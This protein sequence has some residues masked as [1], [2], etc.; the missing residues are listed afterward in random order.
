MLDLTPDLLTSATLG[1]LVVGPL[2]FEEP[3][4]L[5]LIPIGWALTIWIGWKTIAGLSTWSRR[6]AI[7]IRLIVILILACALA[8]PN[9][10]DVSQD[11]AV[12]VV[13]DASDSVPLPERARA[14]LWVEE[15][16]K[17]H[18]QEKDD[19]FGVI[20]V[21]EDASV[22]SLPRKLTAGVDRAIPHEGKGTNLAE[23][24]QL[25]LAVR[26]SDAAYRLVLA[27]DGNETT[28]D[29]LSAARAAAVLSVPIDV[30]I[31]RYSHESEVIVEDLIAPATARMG[32]N[33]NLR[34][35]ITGTRDVSGSIYVTMNGEQ[36]DLDPEGEGMGYRVIVEEG[37]QV[38]TVPIALPRDGPQ[39]FVARFEPDSSGADAIPNNNRAMATTFVGGEGR[40]LLYSQSREDSEQLENVLNQA[41]IAT[42]VTTPELGP[43]DLIEF[44]A[45]DAIILNNVSAYSFSQAQMEDLRRYVYD[46]GGGLVMVGGPDSLGAGGWIDTPVEKALPVKLD[47]PEKRQMPRGALVLVMHSIEMPRGVYYGQ[48]TAL[49]AIDALTRLDLAG[50]IEYDW[51]SGRGADW[52][53]PISELG[54]KVAIKQSVNRLTF[55]DMPS[56]NPSLQLALQGLQNVEAGNKHVIVISD[57]DPSLDRRL[58]QQ[59]QK[60]Q[61]SIST[62]GVFPHSQGD[63]A[64]LKFMADQTGGNFHAV[65]TNAALASLPQIFI[66]EAQ[67]VRRPLIWEGD[68]FLPGIEPVMAEPMRGIRAVPPI[69][70]YVV[71]ADLDGGTASVTLRGQENDPVSA[72]MQY[73]IG[74]SFVFASDATQRWAANWKGWP[75]FQTFWEQHIRWVMRASGDAKVRVQ[76]E[77]DGEDTRVMV[78]AL[79]P[80]GKRLNFATFRARVA[81]PDGGTADVE[82]VQVSPGRYEG[83]FKS[84]ASGQYLMN[85][86]YAAPGEG[87]EPLKGNVQASVS[88]PFADEFR[89][90]TDNAALLT[91]VAQITGGR[92][93]PQ[94]P[95]STEANL[96]VRDGLDMPVATRPLWLAFTLFG[97]GIF[98]VDVAVRR[99]RIDI[100]AIAATVAGVFGASKA[101]AGEQME[102]LREA[103]EKAR[104]RMARGEGSENETE[105]PERKRDKKTAGVKFEASEDQLKGP[106]RSPI[107]EKPA[108]IEKPKAPGRKDDAQPEE[109]GM[110]RLMRAKK[111]AREDF[112]Q[113]ENE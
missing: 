48:Q 90:L 100:P 45:Y 83:R 60:A 47:P 84:E 33:V 4:W 28:G 22:E 10:R 85:I 8:R 36:L 89:A 39:Q 14:D 16:L 6:S 113:N 94:N 71:A 111:R 11:V 75:M 67:T 98:L 73:G 34:L 23:G 68:P 26:P 110:S 96:W 93:L 13:T 62:V 106:Q 78:D 32:E 17:A 56:F 52:V 19:R 25:G 57:G 15:A 109:E 51:N 54:D 65:T 38:Y 7:A 1:S 66:K 18:K 59:F 50:I 82:L 42:T 35:R 88:R 44:N 41:S 29:L 70:G 64:T 43:A 104:S 105:P 58:V 91:Q 77:N 81:R 74:R 86:Q 79:T 112:D 9:S 31:L 102:S 103:R 80:D 24:V 46:A 63:L 101:K 107:T 87:D 30:L 21:A 40:V 37:T 61:I 12:T 97:I 69:T 5:L 20:T 76:T 2:E 27:T 95:E 92:V 53:H 3:R 108:P 55:G 72:I 49:A 99:V